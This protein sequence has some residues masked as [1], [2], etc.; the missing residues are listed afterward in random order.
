M[1]DALSRC[2]SEDRPGTGAGVATVDSDIQMQ[3]EV[4]TR[5][6]LRNKLGQFPTGVCVVTT[7]TPNGVPI[8]LTI[9]SF[10][11][12]SLQPPLVSW[13]LSERSASLD[14]Y[15]DCRHFAVSVLAR[16]QEAVASRFANPGILDKFEGVATRRAFAGM[17]LVEGA[18]AT[19]VC[20]T[21]RTW[22]VGDHLLIVGK[23]LQID[24][25]E[26]E[27]LVFHQGRFTSMP[28]QETT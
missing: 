5:R 15:R 10:A 3:A 20:A 24:G 28:L 13:S 21:Y 1:S 4:F 9:N 11:P 12:V 18:V 26:A 14:V 23:V 25:G 6:A 8:G 19:F 27:P 7:R 22:P 17:P 16:S 2:Y